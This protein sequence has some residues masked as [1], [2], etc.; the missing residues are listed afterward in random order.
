MLLL[1]YVLG[2]C[3]GGQVLKW[4]YLIKLIV[5]LKKGLPNLACKGFLLSK[6]YLGI[7]AIYGFLS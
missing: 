1:G 7:P 6:V 5:L 4:L 2:T 3:D